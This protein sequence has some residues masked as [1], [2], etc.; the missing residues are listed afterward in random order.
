MF[1]DLEG[2]RDV[3]L[4]PDV[5]IANAVAGGAGLGTPAVPPAEGG[6]TGRPAGL[7]LSGLVTQVA[8]AL[9]TALRAAP[10]TVNVTVPP[11]PAPKQKRPKVKLNV[12]PEIKAT[13][14]QPKVRKKLVRDALG[15]VQGRWSRQSRCPARPASRAC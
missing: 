11:Q 6:A 3:L 4:P 9:S 2:A 10:I 15:E 12:R 1:R 13:P 8:E 14:V 5:F 7:D